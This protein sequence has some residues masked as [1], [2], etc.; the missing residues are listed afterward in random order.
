MKSY[1]YPPPNEEWKE[2]AI[3]SA[4]SIVSCIGSLMITTA[5][6]NLAVN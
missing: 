4:Q 2:I 6:V 3:L 1:T 5:Y